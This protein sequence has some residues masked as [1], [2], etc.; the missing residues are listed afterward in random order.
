M[1]LE[2]LKVADQDV[3]RALVL[4]QGVKIVPGLPVGTS[5]VAA[6]AFLFDQQ[7]AR[8]E[9]VDIAGRVVKA[10]DVL[11]IAR[12]AA[13]PDP[14]DF[15]EVVVKAVGLAL[16]IGRV[17]PLFGKCGGTGA[18]FVP[19]ELHCVSLTAERSV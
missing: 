4:G 10:L 5:Q 6:G 13:P 3:A 14:E 2:G 15:E 9:Q 16:F 12:H 1:Q 17:L 19:R 11:L 18:D 7:H 8:P